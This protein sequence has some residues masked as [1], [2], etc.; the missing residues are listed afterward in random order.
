MVAIITIID[1]PIKKPNL[2]V[3]APWPSGAVMDEKKLNLNTH[4]KKGNW[5]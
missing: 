5:L 1:Q 4:A 2:F 3:H